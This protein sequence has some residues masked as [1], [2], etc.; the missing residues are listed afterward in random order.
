VLPE[1]QPSRLPTATPQQ[2]VHEKKHLFR[3]Q[4]VPAV[5]RSDWRLLPLF[6]FRGEENDDATTTAQSGNATAAEMRRTAASK[7]RNKS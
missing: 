2:T 6:F 3:L 5:Y 1:V 4:R 7:H